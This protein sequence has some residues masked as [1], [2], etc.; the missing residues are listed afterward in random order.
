M[1]PVEGAPIEGGTVLITDG[2]IAAVGGPGL[3]V[4][5]RFLRG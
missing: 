2:K 1:V 4:A 5:F 3:A